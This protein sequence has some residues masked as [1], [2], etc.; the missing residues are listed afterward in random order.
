MWLT[1]G[2][3]ALEGIDLVD[4]EAV[5]VAGVVGT[6]VYIDLAERAFVACLPISHRQGDRGDRGAA[7]KLTKQPFNQDKTVV[8]TRQ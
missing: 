6:L 8:I 2:A 1:S 5:V 3:L 7:V 4:A